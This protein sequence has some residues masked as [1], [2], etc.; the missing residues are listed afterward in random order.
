[1][2]C[3]L[4]SW[5]ESVINN[6]FA[7]RTHPGGTWNFYAYAFLRSIFYSNLHPILITPLSTS[8]LTTVVGRITSFAS[9]YWAGIIPSLGELQIIFDLHYFMLET[10]PL[11]VRTSIMDHSMCFRLF[12]G[13]AHCY[14]LP[15]T[16][17][18]KIYIHSHTHTRDN[19]VFRNIII[20]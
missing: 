11:S 14:I 2:P 1:M 12:M 10:I 5:R 9:Y 4:Q 13:L 20:F 19:V 16:D 15:V 17:S 8:S 7:E 6:P 3:P 18:N